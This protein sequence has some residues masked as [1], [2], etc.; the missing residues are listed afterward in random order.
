M[1]ACSGLEVLSE[2]SGLPFGSAT[3][4]SSDENWV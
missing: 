4:D 3:L 1:V 2:L